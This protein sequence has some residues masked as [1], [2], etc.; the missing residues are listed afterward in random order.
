MYKKF[1][2][3][4][5][6]VATLFAMQAGTF[7]QK[8]IGVANLS[9][10]DS[11]PYDT[12]VQY[13][14][15]KG[16]PP[17][18][19]VIDK[20]KQYNIVMIGEDHWLKD[21]PQFISDLIKAIHEDGSVELDYLAI[22][23]G[24]AGDQSL[25]D[26]FIA[27]SIYREGLAIQILQN[28]SDFCGWPYQEILDIFKT[29]WEENRKHPG[30]KP[31]KIL[32]TDNPYRA[33]A[34]DGKSL[35]DLLERDEGL[36]TSR[37]PYM[38]RVLEKNVI[39]GDLRAIY[40]CGGGHSA[41]FIRSYAY[42][43]ET[44]NC[45]RY[46]PAGQLLKILYPKLVFSIELYGANKDRDYYPSTNPEDWDRYLDGKMDEIFRRNGNR[47]VGFDI[48]EPPFSNIREGDYYMFWE[49]GNR[50]NFMKEY[51][52]C[53]EKIGDIANRKISDGNDGYIFLKPL[54]QYEGAT[55]CEKFFD[56]AFMERVSKRKQG[57]IKTKKELY[58]YLLKIR[59]IMGK[60]L[61]KLIEKEQ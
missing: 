20:L 22:E 34:R 35:D 23:F 44:G 25:A 7:A 4:S 48:T 16:K 56:D 8:G 57:K 6:L 58:E 30:K 29:V 10:D 21:H 52:K 31:I 33:R 55:V 51:P 11:I 2:A 17:T 49:R 61:K 40:Y 50:E 37:D 59:P 32:L 14:K 28:S 38:A 12:Y 15:E 19:Y 43:E 45:L 54:D 60:S 42:N 3:G 27:S 39:A 47:P 18:D 36:I 24:N 9:K 5:L 13:L 26:E 53:Y 46:L 41:Y 1:F